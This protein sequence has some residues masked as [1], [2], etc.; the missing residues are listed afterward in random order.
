MMPAPSGGSKPLGPVSIAQLSVS[1]D[2]SDGRVTVMPIPPS[3]W[4][5]RARAWCPTEEDVAGAVE[6]DLSSTAASGASGPDVQAASAMVIASATERP[7]LIFFMLP[8]SL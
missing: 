8:P 4:S 1:P 6:L 2:Q 3:D 5:E 7:R